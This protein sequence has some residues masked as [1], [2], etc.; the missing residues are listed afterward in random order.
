MIKFE[1]YQKYK[2]EAFIN[3]FLPKKYKKILMENY[4]IDYPACKNYKDIEMAIKILK[5]FEN[6]N[7][8]EYMRIPY[9]VRKKLGFELD[10]ISSSYEDL[11]KLKKVKE[12]HKNIYDKYKTKRDIYGRWMSAKADINN[13]FL[14]YTF[15]KA[16]K[17]KEQLI[18]RTAKYG[19]IGFFIGLFIEVVIKYAYENYYIDTINTSA[20]IILPSFFSVFFMF[21]YVSFLRFAAKKPY[22][23]YMKEKNR[24]DREMKKINEKFYKELKKEFPELLED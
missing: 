9:K 22:K 7:Y 20:L 1:D 8:W 4:M 3:P 14:R 2:D 16:P 24:F 12:I 18:S 13:F 23:S 11:Q 19:I 5:E 17:T 21:L 15:D 10:W 6:E